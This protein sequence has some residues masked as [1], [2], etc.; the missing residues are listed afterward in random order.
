MFLKKEEQKLSIIKSLLLVWQNRETRLYYHIGMLNFDG[1]QYTFTYTH[2]SESNRSVLEAMQNGYNLHPA[3]PELEKTYTGQSLFP[4]FNRRIPDVSRIGYDKILDE[5]SL[6][7]DADRM[8]VLRETRGALAGDPYTFEEPLRLN[9]NHLRSNFYINGMRHMENIPDN[10]TDYVRVGDQL[11]TEADNDNDVDPFAV[12]IKAQDGLKLGY[13]PGI[14][15]QALYALL[16]RGIDLTLTVTQL[17]PNFSPQWWVRVE[18]SAVIE[19]LKKDDE[20]SSHLN[21]L[22]FREPA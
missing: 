15:S 18:L 17:H 9:G 5:F 7:A 8:D 10:W 21:S 4:A 22:I 14:Y 20:V 19:S 13:V 3:F 12:S 2:R 16:H 6:P 11:M 1:E